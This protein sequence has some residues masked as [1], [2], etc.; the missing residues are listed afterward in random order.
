[1]TN[2]VANYLETQLD[3]CTGR[4][5]QTEIARAAGFNSTNMLSMIKAGRTRLPLKRVRPLCAVLGIR[6]E[7][8]LLLVAAEESPD[9]ESNPFWIAFGGRMPSAEEL[10][11][12]AS[13]A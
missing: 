10:R 7:E 4:L 6:P 3:R 13:A 5:T 2:T 1:M 12:I 8:L 9:D 11:S